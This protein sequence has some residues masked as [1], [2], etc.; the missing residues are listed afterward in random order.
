MCR[1]ASTVVHKMADNYLGASLLIDDGTLFSLFKTGLLVLQRSFPD[2]DNNNK[3]E[4]K[5]KTKQDN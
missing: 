5:T 3:K 2:A 4:T 1:A